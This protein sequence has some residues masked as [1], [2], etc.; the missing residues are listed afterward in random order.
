MN[1]IKILVSALVIF[2]VMAFFCTLTPWVFDDYKYGSGGPSPADWFTAQ[3]A[4]HRTWSGKFIGHFM[5][6]A[7]LLGPAWLHPLLSPLIFTGLVICGALL[8]VGSA[9]REK[10]RAW[11]LILLAG[12]TW[13]ALPAFGTVYF[14]RTGT[15]DYGYGLFFATVFLLPYRF[16]L[17]DR[18]YRPAIGPFLALG[19]RNIA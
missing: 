11:H 15:A 10:L 9:W 1:K 14:W 19:G 12:L 7:L 4:E 17:D 5:A 13:F 16:W 6:R 2:G 3:L 8:T 18:N